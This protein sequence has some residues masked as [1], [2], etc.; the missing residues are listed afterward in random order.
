M[1]LR[2]AERRERLKAL[3]LIAPLFLFIVISFLVPILVMLN[4]AVYD[5]DMAEN[6]P[7]TTG[8]AAASGT[9]RTLPCEEVFA[10]FAADLKQA[11]QSKIVAL[12]GKRLNYEISGIQ[13]KVIAT[14]RKLDK[15]EAGPWKEAVIAIDQIWNELDTWATI[16]RA[17]VVLHALYLLAMLDLRQGVDGCIEQV[18]A[19]RAVYIDILEPT[20]GICLLVTFCTLILGYPVAYMLATLPQTN[21]QHPDDLRAAAV[22]DLAAGAHH[23]LDH[24]AAGWRRLRAVHER[25]RHHLDLQ[26]AR[27][28]GRRAAAVQDALRHRAWP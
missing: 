6:L 28:H 17:A 26:S 2:P 1:A 20:L 25:H 23:G 13:S 21:R 15:I 5:P 18:P 3:G 7:Q 9:A 12:V 22:L 16:K 14:G 19:D 4:N 8:R 27:V 10:A 11:Q 24:P